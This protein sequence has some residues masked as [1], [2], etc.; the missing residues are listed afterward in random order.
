VAKYRKER[1]TVLKVPNDCNDI[2]LMKISSS[3]EET[4]NNKIRPLKYVVRKS[5]GENYGHELRTR[6][7]GRKKHDNYDDDDNNDD[8]DDDDEEEEEEEEEDE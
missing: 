5:E 6:R 3:K 8:D 2:T 1:K 7:R 4:S